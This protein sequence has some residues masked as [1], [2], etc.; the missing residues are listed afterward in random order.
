MT[1]ETKVKATGLPFMLAVLF[2]MLTA[3]IQAQELSNLHPYFTN[4]YFVDLG[5][6]F[7][8][9]KLRIRANAT[10]PGTDS[11]VDFDE[12]LRLKEDD[13]TFALNLGWRFGKKWSLFT[14][15]FD[16]SVSSGTVLMEDVEWKDSVFAAGSSVTG[17]QD[18]TL[19]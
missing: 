6:F 3:P 2:G 13:E 7:P 9:R 4:R 8:D 18:F 15:Y 5:V 11:D 12:T 19:F 10:L 14:Q 17:G 1:I 16:S